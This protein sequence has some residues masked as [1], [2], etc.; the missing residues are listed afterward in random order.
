[1]WPTPTSWPPLG[2]ISALD[3]DADRPRRHALAVAV[4]DTG[5][6]NAQPIS[7]TPW[8]PEIHSSWARLAALR[9]AR[10]LATVTVSEPR[11]VFDAAPWKFVDGHGAAIQSPS[12]FFWPLWTAKN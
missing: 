4:A 8:A 5:S 12:I 7:G 9:L 1:M 10:F 2:L 6:A 3:R 11:G